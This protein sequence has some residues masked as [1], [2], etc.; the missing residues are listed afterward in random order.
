L[1]QR[2]LLR[3]SERHH[4]GDSV[5]L[6]EPNATMKEMIIEMT[7]KRLGCVL[8]KDAQGRPG[9][10]FTDGD[11]RRRAEKQAEFFELTAS[12][13]MQT[14][15][16]TI[17]VNALLDAALALM[18]KHSITQLATV[19]EPGQLVGIIH[20]HDILKSKLV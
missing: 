16:K 2:L 12:A 5:P 14:T 9:G 6:V 13:A 7:S 17:S 18:E 15:P 4:T 1:G 20:L 19:D 3:V 8:M 10:I 11:L